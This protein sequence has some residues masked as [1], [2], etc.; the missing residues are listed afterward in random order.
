MNNKFLKNYSKEFQAFALSK[1]FEISDESIH[2]HLFDR[3]GD[4]KQ[5]SDN[6]KFFNRQI[7]VII[8]PSWDCLPYSNTSPRKE[9][10]SKRYS[11]LR[12]SK[13]ADKNRKIILM[14][15]DSILQKIIPINEIFSKSFFL[16]TDQDVNF[17]SLIEWLEKMGD[18][19]QE[20]VYSVGEYAL[21]GGIL[22]IYVPEIEHPIRL[23]FFGKKLEKIRT[24]DPS[25]QRSN[26]SIKEVKIFPVSEI[27]LEEQTIDRF[28]QN[29]RRTVGTVQMSDRVYNSIS[30]KVLVEGIEHWLPLFTPNLESIFSAFRGGLF[31]IRS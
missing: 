19:R 11:A 2:I 5:F 24:F 31:F 10:I 28:R 8:F 23:D 14:S 15:L 20:N 1:V 3:E 9:I 4:L 7:E 22:D 30:E 12:A 6:I 13:S 29:Y 27:I 21:R 26:G 16:C 25:S 18:S 17:R